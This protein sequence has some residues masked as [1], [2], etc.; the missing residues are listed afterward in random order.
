[1]SAR[2]PFAIVLAG[3]HPW[4]ASSF[5][6]LSVRPLVPVAL[7]PLIHYSLR[8]LREGGIRR[9]TICANHASSAVEAVLGD[10]AAQDMELSYYRD[11]T[12]R[13]A[14]GCVRDAGLAA[15]SDTVVVVDGASV[16]TVDLENLLAAH[17]GSGAALTAVVHR[18]RSRRVPP[19]PGGVYVLERRVLEQVPGS[20]YQDIKEFL[21]PRLHRLGEVVAAYE[22]GGSCPRV[23]DA[24][25]YLAVNQW[26][27]EQRVRE[28]PEGVDD[29]L[30]HP[31]ASVEPGARL[32]GP[33]QL[34]PGVRVGAGATI[35]G[36]TSIGAGA[37][38]GSGALVARSVLWNRCRVGE[39]S[40][41]HGC[42]LGDGAVVPPSARLF[43]V[44]RRGAAE[45]ES[46]LRLPLLPR[47]LRAVVSPAA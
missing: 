10:G 33:V 44:I 25:T 36:P 47:R 1:M 21:I 14:A 17:R 24:R 40:V 18:D 37:T 31:S 9:A 30:A 5:E 46:S 34:G 45:T 2:R 43:H 11:E 12:P 27:L 3:T 19:S 32:V 15:G 39:G 23:L 6:A 16:P 20:G 42:V 13:G 35:V 22:S 38:V 4:R 41:V 28:G 8:W 7:S 26:V 29:L